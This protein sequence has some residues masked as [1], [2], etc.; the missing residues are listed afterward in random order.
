MNAI[1]RSSAA[2][3]VVIM[4]AEK[5]KAGRKIQHSDREQ[6]AQVPGNNRENITGLLNANYTTGRRSF[7]W[8]DR[9]TSNNARLDRRNIDQH[10][11]HF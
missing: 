8:N 10:P 6:A 5:A 11:R 9:N 3:A 4:R 2:A 7:P 1:I